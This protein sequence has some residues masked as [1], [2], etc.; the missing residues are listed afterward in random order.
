MGRLGGTNL[1][2]VHSIKDDAGEA[3]KCMQKCAV[4]GGE[5]SMFDGVSW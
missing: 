4:N 5:L 2:Q 1:L 3:D